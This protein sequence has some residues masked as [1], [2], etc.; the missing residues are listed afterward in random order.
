MYIP[1]CWQLFSSGQYS[2]FSSL[3]LQFF[4][5]SVCG[6]GGL[7]VRIFLLWDCMICFMFLVQLYEIFTQFLFTT[8]RR[9]WSLGKCLS[10]SCRNC[11]PMLVFTDA[12]YGGLNHTMSRFFLS[13]L[14]VRVGSVGGFVYFSL[15][16]CPLSSS[17][18]WY[19][20]IAS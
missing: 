13:L 9:G 5:I 14:F 18:F 17:A 6:V 2:L 10:M 11:L 4:C 12:L 3:Q 1:A 15:Y 7:A 20:G 8:W 19:G 16:L